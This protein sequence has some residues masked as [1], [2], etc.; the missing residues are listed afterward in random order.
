[1]KIIKPKKLKKGDLIGILSPASNPDNLSRI[2]QGVKYLE[3]LGYK[4]IIGENVGKNHGY[5][6]GSDQERLHDLHSLF[7]N[8]EVK[9]IIC[10]RGGYGT[11]RLLD[12]ID[13]KLIKSNPKIFVGYSDITALQMAFLKNAG[14]LTFAGPMLAVDLYDEVEPYT[15]EFFWRLLTSDKKLGKIELPEHESIFKLT[16]GQAKGRLIGGN[17]ALI[18]S[19]I[20]TPYIPSFKDSILFLEEVGEVPYRVDRMLSQIKHSGG[21]ES[22]S[23]IILGA[24][25]DCNE[26]DPMKKTLSLGEVIDDYFT[27]LKIPVIYNFPHGHIPLMATLPYGLEVKINA[28][29]ETVEY[30]EA[31]V[32]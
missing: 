1:M 2:E 24:F 19:I 10:V 31:A 21:F 11:P 9:A 32:S 7:Q 18:A 5:L 15:E 26:H 17:L 8:K 16:S 13:Y 3:R 27:H 14:L 4:T 25:T 22:L 29:K 20:G 6:A 30:L 28:T 12:K 23:G